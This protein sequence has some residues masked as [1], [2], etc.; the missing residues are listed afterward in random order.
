MGRHGAEQV[1]HERTS[2]PE[3]RR[4]SVGNLDASSNDTAY[5]VGSKNAHSEPIPNS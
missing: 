5:E 2:L 3:T 1:R 4:S